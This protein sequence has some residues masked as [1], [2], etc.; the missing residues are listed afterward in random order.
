MLYASLLR[1][2]EE[3]KKTALI[4]FFVFQVDAPLLMI[5]P[6]RTQVMDLEQ[7][8]AINADV[9]IIHLEGSGAGLPPGD[10]WDTCLAVAI[11]HNTN[12]ITSSLITMAGGTQGTV[13]L[14]A[15]ILERLGEVSSAVDRLVD[16]VDQQEPGLPQVRT[17]SS[18]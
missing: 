9:D 18:L 1:T 8:T 17:V 2:I 14:E 10:F 11:I 4:S 13:G 7:T 6:I 12:S 5:P 3:H 15:A 16:P